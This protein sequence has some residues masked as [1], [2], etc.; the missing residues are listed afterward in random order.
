MTE[1]EQ[2][3][4]ADVQTVE[5]PSDLTAAKKPEA[6]ILRLL[7]RCGYCNE[8]TFAIKLTLE[9][10]MTNA[11]KHGNRNDPGKRVII[12]YCITPE[13]AYICVRDE[14]EGFDPEK[15]PDPTTPERLPL[16]NG[17]GIML[18]RAYMDELHYRDQ[19]REVVFVK[20]RVKE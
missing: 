3:N 14:G 4:D 10:A 15:V 20:R 13:K 18:M 11:V 1:H 7:R 17:R 16:P 6:D 12:R 9:E 8:T 5:I 2:N 19:G